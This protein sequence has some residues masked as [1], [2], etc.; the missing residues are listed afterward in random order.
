M[1]T[2]S[3]DLLCYHIGGKKHVRSNKQ[4]KTLQI[5][6]VKERKIGM[7]L[8]K[9]TS[10]NPSIHCDDGQNVIGSEIFKLRIDNGRLF[11]IIITIKKTTPTPVQHAAKQLAHPNP[12]ILPPVRLAICGRLWEEDER[13]RRKGVDVGRSFVRAIE[14]GVFCMTFVLGFF[15][16]RPS[17]VLSSLV[18]NKVE[19]FVR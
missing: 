13:S 6:R 17:R 1:G 2:F 14:M 15:E 4:T 8:F 12:N 16:R 10:N 18:S 9:A 7:L 19:I 5:H 11:V 3:N